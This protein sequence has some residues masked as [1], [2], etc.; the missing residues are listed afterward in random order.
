MFDAIAVSKTEAHHS[1]HIYKNK[2]NNYFT[3]YNV[4]IA[5]HSSVSF[6]PTK[7]MIA[8]HSSN[9][10]HKPQNAENKMLSIHTAPDKQGL[11][12]H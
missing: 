9:Y 5:K 2:I 6:P 10:N 1:C 12:E 7:V 8:K 4:T 3:K 11:K